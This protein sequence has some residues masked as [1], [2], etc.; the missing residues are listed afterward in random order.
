VYNGVAI[1][2]NNWENHRTDTDYEDRLI[3]KQFSFK[4]VNSYASLAFIAFAKVS[5]M[6]MEH[7]QIIFCFH[8]SFFFFWTTTNAMRESHNHFKHFSMQ[9]T[10]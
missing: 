1:R 6:G 9:T 3:A 5:G 7:P 4:F 2:M 10:G 8:F